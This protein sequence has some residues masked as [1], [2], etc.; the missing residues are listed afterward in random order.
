[1]TNCRER[2]KARGMGHSNNMTRSYVCDLTAGKEGRR[3]CSRLSRRQAVTDRSAD[4]NG[5]KDAHGAL[6]EGERKEREYS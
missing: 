5:L 3:A 4:R 2:K 1:M 6:R